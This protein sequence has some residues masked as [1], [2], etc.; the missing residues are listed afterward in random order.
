MFD[1]LPSYFQINVSIFILILIGAVAGFTAY[2]QYRR[3]IPPISKSLRIFLGINRGV[4]IAALMMLI[5]TPEMTAIWQKIEKEKLVIVIDK[6]ASM[7]ITEDGKSRIDRAID[8]GKEVITEVGSGPNIYLFA[9]DKDT[10]QLKSLDIDTTVFSTNIHRALSSISNKLN[11]PAKLLLV[12]DGNFTEGMNPL[13]SDELNQLKIYPIGV[14]DTSNTQDL[15][16]SEVKYNHIVYQNQATNIRALVA[17]NGINPAKVSVVLKNNGRILQAK[18]LQVGGMGKISDVEFRI[19]PDEKGIQQYTVELE[20]LPTELNKENNT[21]SFSIEVL[22]DKIYVGL[23]ASRPGYESKF[24]RHLLENQKEVKFKSSIL[25]KN[26]R[27]FLSEPSEM[28]DSLDVIIL[29][30]YPST[31]P[32]ITVSVNLFDQIS[33]RRIPIFMVSGENLQGSR[34]KMIRNYF[35]IQSIKP[36]PVKIE[37]QV[38]PADKESISPILDVF[39]NESDADFLWNKIPPIQYSFSDIQFSQNIK[40]ILK[41]TA[42]SIN[43]QPGL[44]VMVAKDDNDG[45]GI[46]LL[47]TGFWRWHFLMVEDSQYKDTWQQILMNVIRWL[48]TA[49]TAKNV[50]LSSGKKSYS[51][52]ENI[53]LLTQV[54]DGAFQVINNASIQTDISGPSISFRLESE[55][56]DPG[57]YQSSFLASVPGKYIIRA[58]AWR[59]NLKIGEDRLELVVDPLNTEFISTKQNHLFLRK[60]ADKTGGIYVSEYDAGMITDILD[61]KSKITRQEE[62]I[63]LWQYVPYLIL[64]I[65]LF[66][67]EWII[68]KRKGLA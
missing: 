51:V 41:T 8:I 21:Y 32:D 37:T 28:I 35:T 52:G 36:A 42:G 19:I 50:I 4:A 43:N 65:I 34:Y 22:K 57:T 25:K 40:I 66:S 14:G 45:K 68:R 16:I 39:V 31:E 56:S 27:F 49:S 30:N 7:R 60:L 5:F 29:C 58:E 47:G 46:L 24:L 55:F 1:Q 13:F 38:S 20:T 61:I 48:D 62:V 59:N 33:A 10:I 53:V 67:L 9:F 3:T 44:P 23:L 6:S 63:E 26:G 2:Y 64:I 17:S 12:T 15:L 18:D 54:Y 11:S